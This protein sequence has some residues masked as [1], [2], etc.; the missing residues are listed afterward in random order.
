MICA[1][2]SNIGF[3]QGDSGGPLQYE[4]DGSWYLAGATSFGTVHFIKL[5]SIPQIYIKRT[6]V[7]HS[8][9]SRMTD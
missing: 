9:I 4:Y 5:C 2:G 8:Y 1:G 6:K 3:C 7:S